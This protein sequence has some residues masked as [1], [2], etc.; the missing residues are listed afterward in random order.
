MA[1]TLLGTIYQLSITMQ[2]RTEAPGP[3]RSIY[4]EDRAGPCRSDETEL[5]SPHDGR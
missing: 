4:R 1:P 5:L 3:F 2:Y